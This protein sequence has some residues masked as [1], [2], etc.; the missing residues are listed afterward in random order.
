MTREI[1]DDKQEIANLFADMG[2]GRAARFC[3]KFGGDL[4]RLFSNLVEDETRIGP[5]ETDPTCFVLQ[6]HGAGQ[7]GQG[8]RRAVQ[9]ACRRIR[10]RAGEFASRCA[11]FLLLRLDGAPLRRNC[12]GVGGRRHCRTHG[13]GA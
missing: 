3:W 6:L 1:G 2:R 8:E 7:C 5:I 13:D 9:R 10:I 11:R 4:F 12:V